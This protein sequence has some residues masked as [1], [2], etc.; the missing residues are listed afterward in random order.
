MPT[1]TVA[2]I[3]NGP[4]VGALVHIVCKLFTQDEL[5]RFVRIRLGFDLFVEAASD[6][7]PLRTIADDLVAY[8]E[9][10][11]RVA[12]F[13]D[14]LALERPQSQELRLFLAGVRSEP[15]AAAVGDQVQAF[16]TAIGTAA[17]AA[18][19]DVQV[20]VQL[21]VGKVR[22][23]A[24]RRELDR[25]ARYKALHDSLHTLHLQLSAITRATQAFPT[26]PAAGRDLVAYVDQLQRQ[27]RRARNSAETLPTEGDEVAWVDEFDQALAAARANARAADRAAAVAPLTAA[28]AALGRLLPEAVRINGE[29]IGAAR[30]LAP[31]LHELADILDGLAQHLSPG[32]PAAGLAAHLQA[33]AEALNGLGPQVAGL[34]DTH[35][36]WQKIESALSTAEAARGGP[37]DQRVPRWPFVKKRLAR[38]CPPGSA[39]DPAADPVA[40]ADQWEKATDSTAA[41]NVFLSLVAAARH[42]FKDV[43][44]RLLEIADQLA[45]TVEVLDALIKVI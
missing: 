8:L 12:D 42:E 22:F 39:I 25:L 19:A 27:A 21:G 45:D 13:L 30:H 38:V 33:G 23:Q 3:L 35:D 28:V 10:Q 2:V 18:R 1:V 4:Q 40:L 5:K 14:A 15:G 24:V 32:P 31:D 44:D 9:R 20:Q 36:A 34:A 16:R 29:M 17:E 6:R 41:E 43:D 26:D 11:G 7:D 37:P